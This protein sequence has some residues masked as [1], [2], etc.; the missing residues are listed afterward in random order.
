MLA[1][2]L[3]AV[4]V[5]GNEPSEPK[6][7]GP[8]TALGTTRLQVPVGAALDPDGY[9]CD[10]SGF[11]DFEN[12]SDGTNLTKQTFPG[13]QFTTTGG[14]TWL[15]GDFSTG[16]YN[17]KY[18]S[19]AYTSR[20]TRW[21]WLGV[22]QGAGRIDLIEGNASVFS[23]LTS[24]LSPVTLE[25]YGAQDQLL[26]SVSSPSG[27]L[28]T[29]QMHELR[30]E[31]PERD[32]AYVIVHDSGNFFLV[33]AVCTDAPGV[34]STPVPIAVSP[35]IG[36]S[37]TTFR[38]AYVCASGGSPSLRITDATGTDATEG[39]TIGIAVTPDSR[40][41][42]Q[43]ALIRPVGVH[44]AV[45]SCGSV[46]LGSVSVLVKAN[47]GYVAIGDSFSSGEGTYVYD[48][49]AKACH[50]GPLAWPR[51]LESKSD[52]LGPIEHKACTGAEIE[53]L[54]N[55]HNGQERQIPTTP[56]ASV[57]WVTLTIGGND[58]GFK[59]ILWD[60]YS[61]QPCTGVPD[62]Q[63][64]KDKLT[65][66]TNSLVNTVYP[67][68]VKAY[69]NAI[70]AHVGYPRLFPPNG[71]DPHGCS[72]LESDEQEAAEQIAQQLNGAIAAA[73][74]QNSRVRYVDVTEIFAGYEMCTSSPWV[75]S[76]DL[77]RFGFRTEQ[78]H[79][80][81]LGQYAYA[82]AVAHTLGIPSTL[83]FILPGGPQF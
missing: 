5:S 20:G 69:P 76:L 34:R 53:N 67:A 17:G 83:G 22:N 4:A 57:G 36:R 54:F 43:S 62:D 74:I 52:D 49:N 71:V 46:L 39:V 79:P 8:R 58:V 35:R 13:V 32:I 60:C 6:L 80:T 56:N 64:F 29:G 45:V 44:F 75:H 40:R 55:T 38:L 28:S 2:L 24:A 47:Q 66:L 12:F 18:P 50:R 51:I 26:T 30:I 61:S 70:I 7:R 11:I 33:D 59:G 78:A 23:L 72:W 41:Y 10:Q 21:A 16:L 42:V 1:D 27:N 68:L 65:T 25:A 77:G 3:G 9:S 19:G 81:Y 14:F 82:F 48:D 73:T 63:G 15:V 37:G 31:R